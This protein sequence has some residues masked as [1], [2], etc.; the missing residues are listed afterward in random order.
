MATALVQ[1]HDLTNRDLHSRD[2]DISL[3]GFKRKLISSLCGIALK[4]MPYD[5]VCLVLHEMNIILIILG[6]STLTLFP[7]VQRKH[8]AKAA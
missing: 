6:S 5:I 7:H 1:A 2:S 8:T 3:L 4:A